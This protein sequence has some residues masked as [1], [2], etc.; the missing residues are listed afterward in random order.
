MAMSSLSLSPQNDTE[1]CVRRGKTCQTPRTW[2]PL[3]FPALSVERTTK[4]N[5]TATTP[6]SGSTWSRQ[7]SLNTPA[8]FSL[9][10]PHACQ[11]R[12]STYSYNAS[13]EQPLRGCS[14]SS[15]CETDR[16]DFPMIIGIYTLTPHFNHH[17]Q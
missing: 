9:P 13:L 14:P 2:F 10:T 11:N 5:A 1:H 6:D 12:I 16:S 17:I 8:S 4:R 3:L 7:V 15:A